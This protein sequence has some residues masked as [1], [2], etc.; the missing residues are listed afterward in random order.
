MTRPEQHRHKQQD[1]HRWKDILPNME[2]IRA[3]ATDQFIAAWKNSSSISANHFTW[4]E[5]MGYV[6]VKRDDANK[7]IVLSPRVPEILEEMDCVFD[8]AS[9]GMHPQALSAGG[10]EAQVPHSETATNTCWRPAHARFAVRCQ[11]PYL[12][13][14]AVGQLALEIKDCLK[15]RRRILKSRLKP[16][17]MLLSISQFPL[18]GSGIYIDGQGP[19]NGPLLRST[20]LSD[21]C[22]NPVPPFTLEIDGICDRR[23]AVPHT[24]VALFRDKATEWPFIDTKLP[25]LKLDFDYVVPHKMVVPGNEETAAMRAEAATSRSSSAASVRSS[26]TPSPDR[27]AD[28]SQQSGESDDVSNSAT[29]T[30]KCPLVAELPLAQNCLLLDTP[31][32]GIGSGGVL[33]VAL[34]AADLDEAR[35][36]YDQLA[37][38]SAILTALTAA[39]PIVRG[40]LVGRDSYWDVQ[41]STVDD[42]SAQELG[43][44]PLT[45]AKGT[46]FKS[47]F[48]SIDIYLGPG[49]GIND[50]AFQPKF[51]DCQYTY[52]NSAYWK[53]KDSGVDH[54]LSQHVAH[55]FT[56]DIHYASER[57]LKTASSTKGD[58]SSQENDGQE[59]F[60]R[61]LG[62]NRQNVCLYPPNTRA[63]SGWEVEL[64]SMEVQLTD[65]EN[66]A[67]IT[68]VVLLSRVII[69]YR[70]NFYLPISLM[71][72]NMARAQKVNAVK[73]QLFYFRRDVFVDRD[74][75]SACSGRILRPGNGNNWRTTHSHTSGAEAGT[76]RRHIGSKS[77]DTAE[78]IELTIDE[79]INGSPRFKVTGILNIILTYLSTMRLEY[80]VEQ[81]LR[82][83]L[84]LIR[85]RASGK[86]CTLATWMR[87]FVQ[88]HPDYRHDSVVLPSINY[89]MLQTMNDIEED[90]VAA[91]ELLG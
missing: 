44:V 83:Q 89:D 4:H 27:C 52:D 86:L 70:L 91:P 20:L 7:R 15:E 9:A 63:G 13:R 22:L 1:M 73:D 26:N 80:E 47:R 43:L 58:S 18:L 62:C 79:I 78:Y 21:E 24:A 34:C 6:V 84:L 66:A 76:A 39:T 45:T 57:M 17:E 36:L 81:K 51:N 49:P 42:R 41:C 29:T 40:H 61:F 3:R 30:L 2:D 14:F 23:G 53:M 48:G 28:R 68:F 77:P 16:D 37:P 65:E 10:D 19:A 85:R 88:N 90:R 71:D 55:L 59:H 87:N 25:P 75:A 32:F 33:R 60:K 31:L 64:V 69:S 50:L 5:T 74:S 82:R 35:C 54:L 67:F 72:Q 11:P 38:I 46:L 12:H 56:R 8:P